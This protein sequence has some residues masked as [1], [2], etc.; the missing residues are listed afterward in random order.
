MLV[1]AGHSARALVRRPAEFERLCSEDRV[2]VVEGDI[3]DRTGVAQALAATDAVIHC[4]DFPPSQYSLNWEALRF[5]LEGLG[6]GRQLVF[7]GNAWVYEPSEDGRLGP[8]HAKDSA[9]RLGQIKADLEKAVTGA[10]GT[11]VTL[12]EVYGPG[13]RKGSLYSWFER[14]LT[15][16]TV[17]IPGDPDRLWEPLYIADAARALVAPLGRARARGADYAACGC[18]PTTRRAFVEMIFRAAGHE[19]RIRLHSKGL[20]RVRSLLRRESRALRDLSYLEERPVLLDGSRI[21]LDLG[22][23]PEV[24]HREGIRRSVRWLRAA[25]RGLLGGGSN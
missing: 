8:G 4:V 12:P 16:K 22:W 10:D 19:P 24:D 6:P 13:V 15:G 1:R 21:R 2:E 23:V 3:L 18:A 9:V 17:Q 25:D 20:S 7:P 11:V 5:V 14:A